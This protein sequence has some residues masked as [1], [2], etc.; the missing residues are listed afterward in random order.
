[1]ELAVEN[2]MEDMLVCTC[3]YIRDLLTL[4]IFTLVEWHNQ[5]L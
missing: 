4:Y 3:V 2:Q 5:A 1:M